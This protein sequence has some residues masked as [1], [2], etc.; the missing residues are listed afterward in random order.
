MGNPRVLLPTDRPI[1]SGDLPSPVEHL[2]TRI[3]HAETPI[4]VLFTADQPRVCPIR[5]PIPYVTAIA[6]RPPATLRMIERVCDVPPA[7]AL[8]KPVRTSAAATAATVTITLRLVGSI[9]P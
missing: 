3:H 2:P 9:L 1:Q 7:L 8:R 6:S 5:R 4:E